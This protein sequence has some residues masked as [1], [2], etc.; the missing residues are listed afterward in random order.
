MWVTAP[1]IPPGSRAGVTGR[2]DLRFR[3]PRWRGRW[4]LTWLYTGG[5]DRC[6]LGVRLVFGDWR[7]RSDLPLLFD[8]VSLFSNWNSSDLS[9]SNFRDHDV[10][11]H[12][13][14]PVMA[15]TWWLHYTRLVFASHS[16][17]GGR[18]GSGGCRR[19]HRQPRGTG[20]WL[21]TPRIGR[22]RGQEPKRF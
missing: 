8:S 1:S 16:S 2:L 19:S 9:P 6:R 3:T 21:R 15:G 17:L 10:P 12:R 18:V 5:L 7:Y 13:T 11:V 20:S 22:I 14:S 4:G